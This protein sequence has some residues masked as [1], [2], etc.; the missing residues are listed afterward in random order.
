MTNLFMPADNNVI[1]PTSNQHMKLLLLVNPQHV[2]VIRYI[3]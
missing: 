2:N 1:I 3:A